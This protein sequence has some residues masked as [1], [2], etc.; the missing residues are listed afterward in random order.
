MGLFQKRDRRLFIQV[1]RIDGGYIGT[2]VKG[3]T[4][5][6]G[7]VQ[8]N[9]MVSGIGLTDDEGKI[10]YSLRGEAGGEEKRIRQC[11]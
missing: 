6:D 2:L 8:D 7:V 4:I 3:Q 10:T 5:L 11:C 9:G 1:Y